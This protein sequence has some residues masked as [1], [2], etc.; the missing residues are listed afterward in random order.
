MPYDARRELLDVYGHNITTLRALIRDLPDHVIRV[1]GTGSE[2]WSILEII[3]HLRD[4][5]QRTFGRVQQMINEDAPL[6]DG[7]DAD[8][9][10]RES[11]YQS[12][13]QDEA[14]EV[15]EHTRR[16]QIAYLNELS[17]EEWTRTAIHEQAG[18][19]TVQS[20]T[21]HMAAHDCVHMAQISRRI[22]ETRSDTSAR[23]RQVIDR[24]VK[25][26]P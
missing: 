10:A 2:R 5:E 16:E 3:C 7:L 20:L 11:D 12:Q 14:L 24:T 26:D 9:L 21:A 17:N 13:S 4:T 25:S 1:Q 19:I 22:Q 18:E 15:F 23:R 6:F 8:A